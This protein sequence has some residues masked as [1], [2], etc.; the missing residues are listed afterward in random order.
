VQFLPDLQGL[1]AAAFTA[2]PLGT[3]L[4]LEVRN[5]LAS[6]SNRA[7]KRAADVAGSLLLLVALAPLLALIAAWVRLDSRGPAL[8]RSE[9]VGRYGETFACLKFRTMFVDAEAR[10]G[11]IMAGDAELRD[12]Y[13]RYH[14]LRDDPRVTRAGRLL[15]RLSL[16]ELP[17]ILNVL[18]GRMSL[19]GPRPYL[20][21]E[22][23]EMGSDRDLV[24]LARPGM[25]G[26]WQVSGRND[27]TFAER[28]AM[29]AHYVRNWSFWWDVELMLRTPIV[30]AQRTGS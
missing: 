3:S 21:R 20:L 12:E 24:F 7:L 22:V 18:H 23:A 19:V 10:L 26:Y 4:A 6:T 8:Y 17:Q 2:A 25:T 29:E 16:D 30:L 13:A 9:R 15:R 5:E 11:A 27:V 14:K 28:Q 1:P